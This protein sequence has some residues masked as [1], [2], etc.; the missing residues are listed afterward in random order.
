MKE[1]SKTYEAQVIPAI[2]EDHTKEAVMILGGIILV[3]VLILLLSKGGKA[4]MGVA[5][6][7]AQLEG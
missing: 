2:K 5:Q 4:A 7:M 3:I 1:Q 6:V